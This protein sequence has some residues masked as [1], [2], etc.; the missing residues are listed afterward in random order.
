MDVANTYQSFPGKNVG[1]E[2]EP[3]LGDVQTTMDKNVPLKGTGI[4]CRK[5][6]K[7]YLLEYTYTYIVHKER[8]IKNVCLNIHTHT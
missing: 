2:T 6:D 5:T 4:V 8:Q 7:T 3:I 1:I